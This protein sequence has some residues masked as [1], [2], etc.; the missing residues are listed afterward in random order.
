MH[1]IVSVLE[2]CQLLCIAPE[3]VPA[4]SATVHAILLGPAVG[5]RKCSDP[6]MPQK[7]LRFVDFAETRQG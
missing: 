1:S 5:R 7:V 4:C 6:E 3:A 2:V